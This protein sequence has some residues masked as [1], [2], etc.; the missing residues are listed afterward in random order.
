M[1]TPSVNTSLNSGR[2]VLS[3]SGLA[4]EVKAL[5]EDLRL[6]NEKIAKLT[7]EVEKYKKRYYYY[8]LSHISS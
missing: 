3:E 7:K 5:R 4:E 1:R 8:L 6:A 2:D